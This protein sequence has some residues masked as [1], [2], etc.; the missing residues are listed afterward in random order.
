MGSGWRDSSMNILV[1]DDDPEIVE[2]LTDLLDSLGYEAY[3]ATNGALALEQLAERDFDLILTDINM[4]VMDGMELIRRVKE[5]EKVPVI[6]VLTAYASMQSAIDAIKLGVYDYITK[7]FKFEI[8]TNAV[9]KAL[10]RQF[11]QRENVNLKEMMELYQASESISSRFS[12][13]EIVKVL[14]ESAA[15][16]TKADFMALYLNDDSSDEGGFT[17]S[18]RKLFRPLS[19]STR[20]LLNFLPKRLSKTAAQEHFTS[21]SS[22]LF[23]EQDP[24][25]ES[26]FANSQ[27]SVQFNSMMAFSLKARNRLVGVFILVSFRPD[28]IFSDKLRRSFYMLVSKAAACIENSYLYNNLQK[29][30][31]ETV[32]SFAL[33]LEAKDSYTHGHSHQVSIY[34]D[35]IARQ[36]GF[37]SREHASLQ[38][39]AILH[40]IG[41]IGISDAILCSQEALSESEWN[42]IRTHS[43]KGR[44]I[45]QPIS[46]LSQV[47]EVIYHHHEHWNGKGYPEGLQGQEIPLMSRIIGVADAFDAMTSKRPYRSSLSIKE[48]LTEL[49]KEAGKQFDPELVDIFI[50]LRYEVRKLLLD[51]KKAKGKTAVALPGLVREELGYEGDN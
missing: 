44:N 42:E 36:L 40:D 27:E 48:A 41:K 22:K 47:A 50:S 7:P 10:E 20:F 13:E 37:S 25:L 46:S 49:Q 28:V 32:E 29:H 16:F 43:L 34:A 24:L 9:E 33:A 26:I 51:F 2:I 17:L 12:L 5:L 18:W 1:V 14:F 39:A 8:V 19:R 38:Q 23:Q 31:I 35:L 3:S 15:S 30:Y 45:V 6:I 21:F 11:L 4:P